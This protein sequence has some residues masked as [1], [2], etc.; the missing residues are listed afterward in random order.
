MRNTR[1][2]LSVLAHYFHSAWLIL[3]NSLVLREY[4]REN[5]ITKAKPL[6][7]FLSQ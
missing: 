3:L 7:E 2:C 4:E 5:V 6:P 1:Y